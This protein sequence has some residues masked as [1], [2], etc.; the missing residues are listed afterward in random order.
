MKITRSMQEVAINAEF[1]LGIEGGRRQ[2][3]CGIAYCIRW[4][5]K[6]RPASSQYPWL[7]PL[8]L[9][10]TLLALELQQE[11]VVVVFVLH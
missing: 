8:A 3:H 9:G 7:A 2:N 4:S 6:S 5:D 11:L 1:C 10:V